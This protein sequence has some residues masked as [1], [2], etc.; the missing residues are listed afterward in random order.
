MG[1]GAVAPVFVCDACGEAITDA[2][3]AFYLMQRDAHQRPLSDILFVHPGPCFE[4]AQS[5]DGFAYADYISGFVT[6]LLKGAHLGDMLSP[7]SPS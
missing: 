4:K 6:T 5:P 2:R 3:Q 1:K 7:D